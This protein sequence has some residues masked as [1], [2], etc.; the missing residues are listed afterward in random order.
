MPIAAVM[1]RAGAGLPTVVAFLT[2][3]CLLALHRLVAWEVP[4]LGWRVALLRYGVCIAFPIA[5]GYAVRALTRA[6]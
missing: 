6:S 2:S 5:A 4:L 1:L 3:W